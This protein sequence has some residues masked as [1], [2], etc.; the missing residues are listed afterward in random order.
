[1]LWF[2]SGQLFSGDYLLVK[3]LD[4]GVFAGGCLEKIVVVG[5]G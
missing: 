5:F 2:F 1:M 3:T 4:N